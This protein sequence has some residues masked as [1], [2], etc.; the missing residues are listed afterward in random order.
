[1]TL[2]HMYHRQLDEP[3]SSEIQCVAAFEQTSESVAAFEQTSDC[4][5]AFEQTADVEEEQQ[6]VDLAITENDILELTDCLDW[7]IEASDGANCAVEPFQ[8]TDKG[9]A[10]LEDTSKLADSKSHDSTMPEDEQS[11]EKLLEDLEMLAGSKYEQTTTNLL[12][13][14][15]SDGLSEE[16]RSCNSPN[17]SSGYDSDLV[18]CYG[19]ECLLPTDEGLF[20]ALDE[21]FSDLF[22]A[23][24]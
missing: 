22:P 6:E 9:L 23:L 17:S 1:M 4:V 21:P 11:V 19:D 8:S 20:S 10:V 7:L 16:S 13:F 12:D 14:I 24:Y 5:A 2:D 15:E 18:S 3:V